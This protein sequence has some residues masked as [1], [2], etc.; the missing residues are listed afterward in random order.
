M[1]S[2]VTSGAEIL[3][4]KDGENFI[5]GG[6]EILGEHFKTQNKRQK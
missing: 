4:F 1:I 5:L 3:N 2:E 6:G